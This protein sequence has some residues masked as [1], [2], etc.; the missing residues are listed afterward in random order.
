[1]TSVPDDAA[2]FHRAMADIY[3][4]AKREAS[5][6]ATYFLRMASDLGGLETAR[7]LLRTSSVSDGFTALWNAGRLDLSVEAHVL[8][9]E[10]RGLFTQSELRTARRR[11]E[12][13]GYR[14]D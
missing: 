4:R 10:F 12:D 2:A 13:Y 1:M 14:M 9:D 6:N 8:K 3:E 5:Y 7:Q 11:L